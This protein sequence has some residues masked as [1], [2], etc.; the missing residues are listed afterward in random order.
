MSDRARARARL[1]AARRRFPR[2]PDLR[3]RFIALSIL[4]GD[5]NAARP[6]LEAWLRDEPGSPRAL[7]L[8][9]R[10]EAEE[11][12]PAQAVKLY[13]QALAREPENPELHGALGEVLLKQ[14]GNEARAVDAFARAAARAA[15]EPRWRAGLAQA[16]QRAGRVD[17]ARRQALRALDL[18]PHQGEIYS[19]VVQ[20]VRRERTTAAVALFAQLTREV[21]T[22]LREE[23]QRWRATWS[24]PGSARAYAA[25]ADFL[26]T[27]GD[28]VAAESQLAEAARL[29]PDAPAL[30]GRLTRFRRLLDAQ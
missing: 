19:V 8:Q 30:R 26:I 12:R 29:R 20:L 16:L 21:E 13:E 28:L 6:L 4:V 15:D 11:M 9:G 7:W 5:R 10:I 3:E 23:A 1:A 24:T 25:L 14:P 17:E 18:D 27:R 2:D 22:R